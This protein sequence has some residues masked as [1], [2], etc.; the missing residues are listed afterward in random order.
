MNSFSEADHQRFSLI[1]EQLY[2]VSKHIRVLSHISWPSSAKDQF[3]RGGAA[4]LPDVSYP[5][6]NS[7]EPLTLLQDLRTQLGDTPVDNWLSKKADTLEHS[8]ALLAATGSDNFHKYSTLLYGTPALPLPDE[9]NTCLGLAEQFSANTEVFSRLDIGTPPPACHL[10]S[11][12]AAALQQAC[13]DCFGNAAPAVQIVEE[14]SANALAGPKRIRLRR[15]ACF[16]DKD[17][18]QLIHHEAFVHVATSLNGLAQNKL[19]ILGAGHP[20]TTKTQEGLAVFAEIITG[21]M[22]LDR[23][24]RL[25]DRVV[26]IQAAID[27]ADFIDIYRFFLERTGSEDQAFEN[28]RR[29]FRG[30]TL[31]GS[32]PFTKD[33]VYLDGLLRVHNFMKVVVDAGKTD[34]LK[35]LF[36][37]KLDIE[38]LP[39]IAQLSDAGLCKAPMYLPPWLADMRYLLFHLSYSTYLSG[40]NLIQIKEHYREMLATDQA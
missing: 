2:N 20:G 16:T 23:M 21:C 25:C 28:S 19:K 30:G 22:D 12:V 3:L 33:I 31:K 14:L 26:A 4:Q 17:V 11:S 27:G 6:F 39:I 1:A 10:A 9:S 13:G 15:T 18:D 24:Q 37:G 35:L 5:D 40:V 36:C 29:V 7:R 34:Y 32:A 38:D 8:V